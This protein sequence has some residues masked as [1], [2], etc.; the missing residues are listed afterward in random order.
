MNTTNIGSSKRKK[1]TQ[2]RTRRKQKL[3]LAIKHRDYLTLLSKS[4]N[5]IRRKKLIDAGDNGQIG[6]VAECIKNIVDGNVPLK[7]SQLTRLKKY[8]TVLRTLRKHPRGANKR[9]S[10]LMQKGG[11]LTTLLPIALNAL[12]G[13]FSGVF[14]KTK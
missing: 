4:K 7:K 9:K 12:S 14:N 1:T 2:Q 8:K 6:A 11:F 10:I 3:P 13:L 5:A